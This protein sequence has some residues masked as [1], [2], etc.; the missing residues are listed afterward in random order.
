LTLTINDLLEEVKGDNDSKK[1][2][3]QELEKLK[4]NIAVREDE[5]KALKPEVSK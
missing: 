2:A 4:A 1:R 5:L 3:Q